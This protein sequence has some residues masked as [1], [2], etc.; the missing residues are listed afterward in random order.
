M[1]SGCSHEPQGNVQRYVAGLKR[2][3]Q[4]G[5]GNIMIRV[6]FA[7]LALLLLASP[8]QA[9][10]GPD[11]RELFQRYCSGC[12]GDEGVG[13]DPANPNGG[14]WDDGSRIAPALNGTAHS[15]HHEPELLFDYVKTGSVD[16][17]SPMP[18]FGDRL[19]DGQVWAIIHYFQSLWPERIRK[20]YEGRFPGS[21]D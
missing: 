3:M 19:N 18:S 4:R 5:S 1:R 6:L 10:D 16:P 20:I 15:W 17:E 9:G 12:H 2:L 13:Q 7:L 8:V 14:W 11:G 21:L